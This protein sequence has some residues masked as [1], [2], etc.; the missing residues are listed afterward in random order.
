MVVRGL[1]RPQ[2]GAVFLRGIP[3]IFVLRDG[4]VVPEITKLSCV[5]DYLMAPVVPCVQSP[6]F[7]CSAP[8]CADVEHRCLGA[9]KIIPRR[10]TSSNRRALTPWALCPRMR[11]IPCAASNAALGWLSRP[12]RKQVAK[13]ASRHDIGCGPH[14][15][16]GK[17]QFRSGKLAGSPLF[18]ALI[19][20]RKRTEIPGIALL[21]DRL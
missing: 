13:S 16:A 4:R 14:A 3:S 18:T 5:G 7:K 6:L 8:G 9:G 15:A 21:I 17:R 10:R 12:P 1:T 11:D 19:R 2:G 20:V